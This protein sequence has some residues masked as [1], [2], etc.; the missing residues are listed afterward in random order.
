[1]KILYILD[2][3]RITNIGQIDKIDMLRKNSVSNRRCRQTKKLCYNLFIYNEES[4]CGAHRR[5]D[6]PIGMGNIEKL[7]PDSKGS[8]G[9]PSADN[10]LFINAIVWMLRT[11]VPWWD[12]P[13]DPRAIQL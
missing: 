7:L 10:R 9:R 2:L 4:L 11:G 13:L 3:N 1:M 12:L 8:I 6:F 5:H